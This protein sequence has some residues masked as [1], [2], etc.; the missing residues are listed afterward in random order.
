VKKPKFLLSFFI[1]A[2]LGIFAIYNL[3]PVPDW[4]GWRVAE[5]VARIKYAL[6][7]PEQVVFVPQEESA[8]TTRVVPSISSTFFPIPTIT[9][10]IT[11]LSF[12]R[13][14][15]HLRQ[16]RKASSSLAS[17]MSIKPGITADRQH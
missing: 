3:L 9:T 7:P 6:S 10:I 8:L 16:Y 17:N 13:Q 4:V 1:V 15:K 2:F 11:S 5:L 14:P 12:P